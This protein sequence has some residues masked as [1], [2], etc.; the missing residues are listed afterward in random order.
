MTTPLTLAI[1]T[2]RERL[3]LALVLADGHVD[4]DIADIAKGHAEIIMDRIGGLLLRNGLAHK[5]LE[6]VAATTGPGSFTGLRIGLSVARGLGLALDIPAI[7]VSTLAAISLGHGGGGEIILD[8]GRGEAYV[9]RFSAPGVAMDEPCLTDLS[10]ALAAAARSAPDD[11]RVDVAALARFA[12]SADPQAF[13]SDPVYIRP[14][15]AKP[16]TRGKVA[17]R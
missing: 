5:D 8:A 7:G 13:P 1:D 14:A 9:Q 10:S 3:Q 2:S 4:A 12:A 6:R 15:D 16:Q 11:W 17:R